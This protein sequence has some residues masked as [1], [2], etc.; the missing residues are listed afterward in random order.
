MAT[1][2]EYLQSDTWK[3]LRRQRMA[4]DGNLCVLCCRPAEHV[5]HRRYPKEL[6]TE[7]V[8]DLVSLCATCHGKHHGEEQDDYD[9]PDQLCEDNGIDMDDLRLLVALRDW[10]ISQANEAVGP[11]EHSISK[12]LKEHK[13]RQKDA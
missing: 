5:H 4:I 7:T 13:E 1:Y 2:E 10:V 8:Q 3:L 11:T 6:G 12:H 9:G